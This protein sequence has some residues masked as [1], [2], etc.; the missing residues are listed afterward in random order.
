MADPIRA[1]LDAALA[2]GRPVAV[3][4]ADDAWMPPREVDYRDAIRAWATQHQ[5]RNEAGFLIVEKR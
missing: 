4:V 1:V 5:G 3:D 2:E